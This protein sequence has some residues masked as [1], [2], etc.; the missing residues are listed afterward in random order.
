MVHFL[1]LLKDITVKAQATIGKYKAIWLD[2][3]NDN[4]AKGIQRFIAAAKELMVENE[5]NIGMADKIN[6]TYHGI[7]KIKREAYNVKIKIRTIRKN[8]LQFKH[9]FI[10]LPINIVYFSVNIV[11]NY[12]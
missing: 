6:A 12:T 7:T 11:C 5:I 2:E 1:P 8:S 3:K 9:I 4:T 10:Y